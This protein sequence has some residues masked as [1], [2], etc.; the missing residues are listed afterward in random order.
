MKLSKCNM[1]T[2]LSLSAKINKFSLTF[3]M[4]YLYWNIVIL[5]N[6]GHKG[7]WNECKYMPWFGKKEYFYWEKSQPTSSRLGSN[8][9]RC[10]ARTSEQTKVPVLKSISIR[11]H[12]TYVMYVISVRRNIAKQK[13]YCWNS[14]FVMSVFS[15]DILGWDI[16]I[17]F[18]TNQSQT[19]HICTKTGSS[20]DI[21]RVNE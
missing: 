11:I 15:E 13:Y 5:P 14:L 9:R 4:I 3:L 21:K 18:I 16:L 7:D 8:W 20:T 12:E 10:H 6:Q 2:G 17:S 19:C 1:S